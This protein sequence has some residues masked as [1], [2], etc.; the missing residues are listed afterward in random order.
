MP[1]ASGF[2]RASLSDPH[3][4]MT[5]LVGEVAGRQKVMG[6]PDCVLDLRLRGGGG[7]GGVCAW[8]HLEGKG[9]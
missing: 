8:G 2:K 7:G 1:S 9:N 4:P 3:P 5:P 6:Y